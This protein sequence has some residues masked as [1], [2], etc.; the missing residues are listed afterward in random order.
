V[1]DA[2]TSPDF[3]Y[4]NVR[5]PSEHTSI[6]SEIRE[7]LKFFPFFK[8]CIGAI[9]ESHISV[10]VPADECARFHNRKGTLSQNILAACTFDLQFAYIL[11]G[12]EGSA[13]DG[14]IFEY[15][16]G[17]NFTVPAGKYYLANAGFP[18]CDALLVPYRGVQYHL[19]EWEV[20]GKRYIFHLHWHIL[21]LTDC[22]ITRPCNAKE[23]FNLHHSQ[24]CNVV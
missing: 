5:L 12:W 14:A 3:Y 1:L 6:P 8:D 15:A 20:V 22:T 11:S 19:C 13:S 23:L 17:E 4:L 18:I 21:E 16:R 7:N 9:D 10:H 24:A 2:L